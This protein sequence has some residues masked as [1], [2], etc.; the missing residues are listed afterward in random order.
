[1]IECRPHKPLPSHLF[2]AFSGGVDSVACLEWLNKKHHLTLVYLN[3]RDPIAEEEEAAVDLIADSYNLKVIK[4]RSRV[5]PKKNKEHVWRNERYHVFHNINGPVITCHHLDDCVETWVWKSL[6]GV[7]SVIPYQ[8]KN[9]IR[10]FRTTRK[11]DFIDLVKRK[12]LF[13]FEDFTNSLPDYATRNYIRNVVMP[14]VLRINPGI[15]TT[16]RK[17]ILREKVG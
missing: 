13:H 12:N 15:H 6:T 16:I 14:H 1:M 7:P 8:H 3:H 17:R 4:F 11:Y 5:V 9:V 2:L 10:P